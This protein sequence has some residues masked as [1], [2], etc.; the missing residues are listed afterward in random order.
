MIGD[1][2]PSAIAPSPSRGLGGRGELG[3]VDPHPSAA[4][5]FS[6][7]H[8]TYLGRVQALR[9]IDLNLSE[10]E[11]VTLLGPSGSGKTTLLMIVAGFELPDEGRV[12]A[13]G[14]DI[15]D[16]PPEHRNFGVVFQNYA[17]FPHMSVASNIAYPLAVRRIK[18]KERRSMVE[19]ALSLVGLEGLGD[20]RAGQLSGGQQQRV[21]LA[22]SLVYRPSLLLLDEPLGALDRALRERM[23]G[24]LRRLHRRVGVTFL[25]VTHDQ[26][27]A[28][29]MSDR[30]AV[31]RN[32]RIEQVGSPEEIYRRPATPFVATFVGAANML[33][34]IITAFNGELARFR[35]GASVAEISVL[36]RR[37]TS[38]SVGSP[39][40]VLVRPEDVLLADEASEPRLG[41][42]QIQGQLV[43]MI[44]AGNVWRCHVSTP[45][46]EIQAESPS[47]PPWAPGD[48]L[49]VRWH[50][51]ASWLIPKEAN[52]RE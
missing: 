39:A 17:L 21:A 29:T 41:E 4:L 23:Q 36:R 18:R 12:F 43:R 38:V 20:R 51:D 47:R 26:T 27:E 35:V 3:V 49:S 14:M 37:D 1:S 25:Y 30:V 8:K 15:T 42:T 45:F 16:V 46:G 31:M 13:Q 48:D 6:G 2:V 50:A 5:R 24:E 44:F 7:I 34:G 32:G 28:L 19:E 11:F 40:L 52:R 33:E 10:G 22:R 9:G